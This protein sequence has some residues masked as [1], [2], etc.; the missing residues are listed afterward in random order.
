MPKEFSDVKKAVFDV[1]WHLEKAVNAL[2]NVGDYS[3]SE[4][5]PSEKGLARTFYEVGDRLSWAFS[6]IQYLKKDIECE[7][8]LRKNSQGRYE[9]PNGDYFTSGNTIEFLDE[10]PETIDYY[11]GSMWLLSRVEHAGDYITTLGTDVSV[12]GIYARSRR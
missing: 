6:R 2:K 12:D 8:L 11:G 9:L 7:G 3:F 1:E 4:S 10:R 5:D